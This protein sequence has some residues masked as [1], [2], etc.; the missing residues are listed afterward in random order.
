MIETVSRRHPRAI[1]WLHWL[2][3]VLVAGAYLLIELKGLAARGTPLRELLKQAHFWSGIGVLALLLPRVWIRARSQAT[4]APA[5]ADAWPRRIAAL[6]HATLYGFLLVQPLLGLASLELAGGTLALP[7]GGGLPSLIAQPDRDLAHTLEEIHETLGNVFYAVIG[8][9]IGAA[10][11]H[12][13]VRRDDTLR[14]ML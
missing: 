8:L 9:H 10:L 12:H 3:F 2:T 1:R 11:W 6:T 14:R 7:G 4:V 13:F 5:T